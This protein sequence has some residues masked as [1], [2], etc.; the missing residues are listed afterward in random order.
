MR[1]LGKIIIEYVLEAKTGL[2]IGAGK[3][4]LEIGGLDNPVI[5][6]PRGV[7]F[8]PGSSIKG[9]MRCLLE[10]KEKDLTYLKR[11]YEGDKKLQIDEITK[12]LKEGNISTGWYWQGRGFIHRCPDRDCII[13]TLFGRPAEEKTSEPT[14]LYVRDAK[15]DE[16]KFKEKFPELYKDNLYTEAKWENTIDRLTSAANP[17]HFERVPAGAEFKGDFVFNVY[18]T[19]RDKNFFT[20]FI[21]AMG[22]LEDD[23]LGGSGSRGYGKVK[24][25]EIKVKIKTQKHYRTKEKPVE[26][27]TLKSVEELKEKIDEIWERFKNEVQSDKIKE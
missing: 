16:E 24:F 7:P 26:I 9:K 11:Y 17:R 10:R 2:S 1:L 21:T 23:Y 5:K 12:E 3:E 8:I 27:D 4:T 20:A 14:R 22:L 15:L 25:K 13:C 6:D 18:D 19:D